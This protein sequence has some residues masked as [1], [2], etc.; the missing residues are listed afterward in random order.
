MNISFTNGITIELP[1]AFIA[2][3]LH[4]AKEMVEESILSEIPSSPLRITGSVVGKPR[5]LVPQILLAFSILSLSP[6]TR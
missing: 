3:L 5:H 1:Y 2:S 4:L 6:H